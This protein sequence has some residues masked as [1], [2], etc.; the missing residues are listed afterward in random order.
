MD[1]KAIVTEIREST[2]LNKKMYFTD[3]Y[4]EFIKQYPQLFKCS[5]DNEFSLEFLDIML[6]QKAVMEKNPTKPTVEK[7][8]KIVYDALCQKYVNHVVDKL[9]KPDKS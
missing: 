7:G 8:D 2:H 9:P 4:P 6:Q 1:I 5:L 3:K